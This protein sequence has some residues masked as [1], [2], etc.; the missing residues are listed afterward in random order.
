M[1]K[2]QMQIVSSIPAHMVR[3]L[4]PT[5]LHAAVHA[6]SQGVCGCNICRPTPPGHEN[7]RC[8]IREDCCVRQADEAQ[9]PASSTIASGLAREYSYKEFASTYASVS[10]RI[11]RPKLP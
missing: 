2:S 8:P 10:R 9:V 5:R 6:T 1:F 11:Q 4:L 3:P 7:A